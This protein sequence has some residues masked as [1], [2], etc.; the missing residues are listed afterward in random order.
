[1]LSLSRD[2]LTVS[3]PRRIRRCRYTY[4]L[5]CLG[6]CF[7]VSLRMAFCVDLLTG[8]RPC[9]PN[10]S[11]STGSSKHLGLSRLIAEQE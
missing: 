11:L 4:F 1:M 6:F 2:V 10:L 7:D 8:V 5:D 3:L 9:L